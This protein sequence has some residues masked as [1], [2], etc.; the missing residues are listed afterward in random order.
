MNGRIPSDAFDLYVSL[1]P[2]RSYQAIADR[3]GVS[4]R[5]V[6]KHAGKEKWAERL[7]RIEREARE[8]SDE[9][10][11]EGIEEMRTRHMKTLK[12]MNARALAALKQYPLTSGMEAM[13]A[14]EMVIK[15]E[16]LIAGEPSERTELSIEEVTRREVNQL[17]VVEGDEDDDGEE[18]DDGEQEAPAAG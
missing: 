9:K 5:A 2:E 7:E 16:R 15:L 1:G 3:Y 14:A 17:L 13:R 8:R 12:A 10:L 6:V 18:E 11:A 4:K